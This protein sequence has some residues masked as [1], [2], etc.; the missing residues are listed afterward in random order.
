MH[1]PRSGTIHGMDAGDAA[2][3]A[4][5]AAVTGAALGTI[6]TLRAARFTGRMQRQSQHEQWRRQGRRDAYAAFVTAATDYRTA[7]DAAHKHATPHASPTPELR[8]QLQQAEESRSSFQRASSV[9]VVEGPT[10]VAQAADAVGRALREWAARLGD[11]SISAGHVQPPPSAPFE[12][13]PA[14]ASQALRSF[15]RLAR[16]ALDDPSSGL[17]R[18]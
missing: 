3:V 10:A 16:E 14:A 4:A 17:G 12:R 15:E 13:L 6:G 1:D 8:D 9:V 11:E 5:V 2:V 18:Q 7:L